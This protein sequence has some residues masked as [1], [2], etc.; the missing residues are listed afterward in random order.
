M[1]T[2][3]AS[4]PHTV[5]PAETGDGWAWLRAERVARE[6][7][8]AARADAELIVA[9]ARREA[10]DRRRA[11]VLHSE[12]A[13]SE[14]PLRPVDEQAAQ[15]VLAA[16]KAHSSAIL[17]RA[18]DRATRM[19][20]ASDA[21]VEAI[22][23][24]AHRR[25]KQ[26]ERELRALVR[27]RDK[28]MRELSARVTSVRT[29]G[30]VAHS[31]R[32][33]R[34]RSSLV[35]ALVVAIAVIAGFV[36]WGLSSR[37]VTLATATPAA[38]PTAAPAS[39]CPIPTRFRP[40]FVS[41]ARQEHVPLSLLTA[42][43]GVESHFQAHLRSPA[44]AFGLMQLMPQTARDLGI[45]RYQWRQNVSGGARLLRQMLDRF[46]GV[47]PFALAAYNAGPNRVQSGNIPLETL[48]YVTA[49]TTRRA[50]IAGCH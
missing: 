42:V 24:E 38:Q 9:A 21:E 14:H 34:L 2:A 5:E 27:E 47:T 11:L 43:A 49:V 28:V 37:H 31:V 39:A 44:G 17:Q 32:N 35:G 23:K 7:V 36:G 29:A 18:I 48:R 40:A 50:A 25:H 1:R 15:E 33:E 10:E 19:Q 30:E 46:G 20:Q 26:L 3:A 6:I 41:A 13:L 4:A 8:A 16:A 12:E 45:N 22:E